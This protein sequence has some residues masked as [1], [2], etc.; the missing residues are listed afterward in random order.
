MCRSSRRWIFEKINSLREFDV[1]PVTEGRVKEKAP[2][3]IP[4]AV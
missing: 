3:E 4:I 2:D 1:T